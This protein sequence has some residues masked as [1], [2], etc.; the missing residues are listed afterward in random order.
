MSS[1]V[2]AAPIIREFRKRALVPLTRSYPTGARNDQR[3]ESEWNVNI[4]ATKELRLGLRLN[5]QLSAEVFNVFDEGT[6]QIYNPAFKRG[7]Q[8]NGV[9][10]ARR[11]FGRQWQLGMKLAF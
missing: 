10:E 1:D 3:N 11:R 2:D 6:Y 9:N 8:F 4:K 5:L 7:A